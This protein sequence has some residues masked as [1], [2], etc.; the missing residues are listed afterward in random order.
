MK[1]KTALFAENI[2]ESTSSCLVM[3][4]QGNLLLLTMGHWLVAMETGIFAGTI[5]SALILKGKVTRPW[6]VS[7]VLGIITTV[8]DFFVHSGHFTA[9]VTEA[10]LTGLGAAIL[11]FLAANILRYV[12]RRRNRVDSALQ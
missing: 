7:L 2:T 11:S 9:V 10:A 4:V 5:A 8:V 3:M 6:V 12:H 1:S